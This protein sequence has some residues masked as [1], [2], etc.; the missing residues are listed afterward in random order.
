MEIIAVVDPSDLHRTEAAERYNIPEER[1]FADLERFL[2]T[3]MECD[4]VIDAIMDEMHY[5]TTK[6]IMQAG[7]NM[8]LEADYGKKGRAA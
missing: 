7:Y 4:F 1:R 2:E 6:A 8:L 3:K 5:S